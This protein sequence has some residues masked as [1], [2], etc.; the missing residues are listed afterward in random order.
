M[1]AAKANTDV[2][3]HVVL[4]ER[5]RDG[6]RIETWPVRQPKWLVEPD[7]KKRHFFQGEDDETEMDMRCLDVCGNGY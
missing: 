5:P 2:T 1:N 4:L 7:S 3:Q 6:R